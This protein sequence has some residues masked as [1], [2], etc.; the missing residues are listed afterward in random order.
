[1]FESVGELILIASHKNSKCL[2]NSIIARDLFNWPR[3]FNF[4]VIT[5]Q[6]RKDCR[7]KDE[8]GKEG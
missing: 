7:H 2:I 6:I 5:E 1:M 3:R 8:T 4:S